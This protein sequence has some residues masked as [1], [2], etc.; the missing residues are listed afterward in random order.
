MTENPP[1]GGAHRDVARLVVE[2]PPD[3]KNRLKAAASLNGLSMRAA[4]EQL[5]A[6]YIAKPQPQ[7]GRHAY[8]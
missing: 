7:G 5:I 3:T 4:I 2:I 6:G 8:Y 1:N